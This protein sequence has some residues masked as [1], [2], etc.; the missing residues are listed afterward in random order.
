LHD[1]TE[2]EVGKLI[3]DHDGIGYIVWQEETC[4]ETGR[5]HL[6]GYVQ[7]EKKAVLSRAKKILFGDKS[8]RVHLEVAKGTPGENKTYCTKVGGRN[9]NEWG[10]M[11]VAG[12]SRDLA[13]IA[14]AISKG[15]MT[16]DQVMDEAP[17]T[18]VMF[19]KGLETL[20][21]AK[22][23]DRDRDVKPDVYWY[24]GETGTGKTRKV[25]DDNADVYT[26]SGTWPWFHGYRGQTTVLFD[27]FRGTIPFHQLLRLTDRYPCT[28]ETKGGFQ[29]WR[30]TK[31]YF[32]SAL[33][34]EDCYDAEKF[35]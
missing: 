1:P 19:G 11:S 32:T 3:T 34:P 23:P 2:L 7:F 15:E 28:V 21:V 8:H 26:W 29:K 22:M 33:K 6:Q 20:A 27:D 4:P 24:Y 5:F 31:I 9:V 10:V 30:A 12:K 16:I 17:A 14:M 13:E 25:Y 18:Y 35:H